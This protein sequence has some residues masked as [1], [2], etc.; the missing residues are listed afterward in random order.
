MD[1]SELVKSCPNCLTTSSPPRAGHSRAPVITFAK[2]MLDGKF[3]AMMPPLGFALTDVRD[4]AAA[5]ILG[6]LNPTS[7]G[8]HVC[9][10]RGCNIIDLM[11]D[12]QPRW[13]DRKCVLL[14][15]CMRWLENVAT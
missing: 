2:D 9:V 1:S 5:H 7:E 15:V 3:A 14:G 11:K 10:G 6:A 4:V 12:L 8:R 13:P